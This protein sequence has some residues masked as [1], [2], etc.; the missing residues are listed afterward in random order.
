MVLSLKTDF[1]WEQGT[2]FFSVLK[3]TSSKLSYC[4][5]LIISDP[6]IR[7]DRG[8]MLPWH[9][10]LRFRDIASQHICDTGFQ[11]F[12][13]HYR[14]GVETKPLSILYQYSKGTD[15]PCTEK[16]FVPF[17]CRK[18]MKT[19][20]LIVDAVESYSKILTRSRSH[21][22]NLFSIKSGMDKETEVLW[23]S[24]KTCLYEVWSSTRKQEKAML[25]V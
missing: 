14:A 4:T 9:S 6:E 5:S 18:T 16:S 7:G 3:I 13:S 15:Q 11:S 12:L 23:T 24:M 1:V 2:V 25:K 21:I 17:F 10:V 22:I 8:H 20:H 19:I